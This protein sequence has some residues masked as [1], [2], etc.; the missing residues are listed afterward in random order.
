MAEQQ[1]RFD[2]GAAYEQVMGVWSRFAGEIFLDWLAP[3]TGLRWLD[4]GCG[5][6]AFTE[7]IVRRCAPGEVQ[8]IDPSEEQLAFA[9]AR[10]AAPAGA[11][12]AGRCDGAA[13]CR[14]PASMPPSWRW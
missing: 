13:V 10:P 12:P 5:N 3:A 1:I 9:R 4:V 7:L 8:G 6:G 14:S 11:I 2:D